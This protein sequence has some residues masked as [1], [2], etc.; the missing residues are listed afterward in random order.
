MNIK[1]QTLKF[2]ATMHVLRGSILNAIGNK[3][4]LR[5]CRLYAEYAGVYRQLYGSGAVD[6]SL[7]FELA[8]LA[9]KG[10]AR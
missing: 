8:R 4:T 7:K 1:N 5:A 9:R 3:D 10:T 2:S 6:N